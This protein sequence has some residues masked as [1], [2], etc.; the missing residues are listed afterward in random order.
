MQII[1]LVLD[2]IM[3]LLRRKLLSYYCIQC[4]CVSVC[5]YCIVCVSVYC[6]LV[7]WCVCTCTCALKRFCCLLNICARF[8]HND[9]CWEFASTSKWLLNHLIVNA[10]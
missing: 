6:V 2:I 9:E 3:N 8:I 4:V 7:W 10:A 1:S 5:V